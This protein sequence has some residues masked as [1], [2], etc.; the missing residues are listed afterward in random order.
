MIDNRIIAIIVIVIF[1][2]FGAWFI[3]YNPGEKEDD[4]LPELTMKQQV[5]GVG[6][7]G[8]ILDLQRSDILNPPMVT[9]FEGVDVVQLEYRI[10]FKYTG[11]SDTINVTWTDPILEFE[12]YRH[13]SAGLQLNNVI[14]LYKDDFSLTLT[15]DSDFVRMTTFK[16]MGQEGLGLSSGET[17]TCEPV[18]KGTL[19][20]ETPS[21]EIE[22]AFP[23]TI[24]FDIITEY[25]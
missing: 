6:Y 4:L 23:E 14:T 2:V 7:N 9:Y 8:Q 20:Y 25:N 17:Y 19:C 11:D 24:S 15:K 22:L 10:Y 12:F 1:V 5:Y 13:T 16:T 18:F 3:L 21:N